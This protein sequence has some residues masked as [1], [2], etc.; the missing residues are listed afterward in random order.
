MIE[1]FKRPL[2]KNPPG[3]FTMPQQPEPEREPVSESEPESQLQPQPQP[4]PQSQSQAKVNTSLIN[5]LIGKISSWRVR[6]E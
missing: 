1:W 6:H 3:F 2:E 5:R 4:E